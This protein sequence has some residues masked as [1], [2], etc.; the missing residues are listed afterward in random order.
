MLNTMPAMMMT[1][2]TDRPIISLV[3]EFPLS[4]VE[5]SSAGGAA[6]VL[7]FCSLTC[8]FLPG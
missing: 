3:A 4:S 5:E 8:G 2:R 6:V 1:A 7:V